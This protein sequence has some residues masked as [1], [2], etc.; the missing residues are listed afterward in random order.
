MVKYS[1]KQ[2]KSLDDGDSGRFRDGTSFRLKN[3]RAPERHQFGG[4]TAKRVLAGM[5]ARS[6]GKV[7][8]KQIARDKYGRAVV[9]LR[10]KDGSINDRMLK[11][12]YRNKGR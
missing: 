12:G 7:A 4:T 10:N 1:K 6:G 11:R 5:L 8:V 9:E 3:V 2:V